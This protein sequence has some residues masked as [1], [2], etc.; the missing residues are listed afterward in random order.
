[1]CSGCF[2]R[3]AS[4]ADQEY[5]HQ[6][7]APYI[8]ETVNELMDEHD[9]VLVG[10]VTPGDELVAVDNVML[11]ALPHSQVVHAQP[12]LD[13][14]YC[15][16]VYPACM[17]RQRQGARAS[18]AQD[19]VN[20]N[21]VHLRNPGASVHAWRLRDRGGAHV[22]GICT[23]AGLPH[24]CQAPHPNVPILKKSLKLSTLLLQHMQLLTFST[25]LKPCLE[26]LGVRR[27]KGRCWYPR[28]CRFQL[29]KTGNARAVD[30]RERRGVQ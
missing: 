15:T 11:D 25:S 27:E 2:A 20:R 6:E 9:R 8:V 4:A 13:E 26:K 12:L 14:R 24:P 28:A 17:C 21:V 5:P 29:E 1:V 18:E 10:R 19:H 16:G 23:G 30:G 3:S 7:R 22:S